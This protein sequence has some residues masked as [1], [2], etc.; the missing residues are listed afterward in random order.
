MAKIYSIVNITP[1]SFFDGSR[2]ISATDGG[3]KDTERLCGMVE[4]ALEQGADVIDLGGYST[5]PGHSEVSVEEE[6]ERLDWGV[7]VIRARFGEGVELSVDSFRSE[8]VERLYRKYGKVVVNDIS[9][10]GEG[11]GR[12]FEVCG[13]LGLEYVLMSSEGTIEGTIDFFR[14]KIAQA[15]AHGMQREQIMLDPGFG[16]GKTL[17]QNFHMLGNMHRLKEFGLP[18]F[19]GVSRKSMIFKSLDSTPTESLNGT[20]VIHTLAL[21]QGASV[22]R[23]HDTQQALECIKLHKLYTQTL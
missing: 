10:G 12:M 22:L 3:Y 17:E 16:F 6:I 20:T 21:Q 1:D 15:I 9:G 8:V 2:V 23:V 5:R 18:I 11:D 13:R 4:R 7:G 19:V 14:R